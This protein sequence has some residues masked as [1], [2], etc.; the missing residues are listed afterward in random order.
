MRPAAGVECRRCREEK[1]HRC[2]AQIFDDEVPLCLPCANGDPCVIDRVGAP[3]L[4][5]PEM[6]EVETS[7]APVIQRTPEE[8]GL[9]STMPAEPGGRRWLSDEEF[10][11]EKRKAFEL[12]AAVRRREKLPAVRV[13][14]SARK[15]RGGSLPGRAVTFPPEDL[16]RRREE[17]TARNVAKGA[18]TRAK[19][20][21]LLGTA[22]DRE[23]AAE[24][25]VSTSRV[26]QLRK[27]KGIP[28][29]VMSN[30]HPGEKRTEE[31]MDEMREA[32]KKLGGTM[33]DAELGQKL[34]VSGSRVGQLRK[35]LGI[36]GTRPGPKPGKLPR[37]STALIRHGQQPVVIDSCPH[38]GVDALA[39]EGTVHVSIE[40]TR[41]QACERFGTLSPAEMGIALEAAMKAAT[42]S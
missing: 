34:G 17:L 33:T 29:V 7:P 27:E 2:Q 10:A 28:A 19:A 9:P 1:Q 12:A 20:E 16:E 40:M 11:Q 8:L 22:T 31:V 32:V 30:S 5:A 24:V 37:K 41:A 13:V 25:G 38:A 21:E 18:E 15:R 4:D 39:G 26:A 6:F 42:R 35:E 23:V 3:R 14:K 36:A